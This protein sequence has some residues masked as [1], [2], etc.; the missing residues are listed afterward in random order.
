MIP[1]DDI[2]TAVVTG[3][4]AHLGIE[5]VRTNQNA[6]APAYPFG[7][8]TITTLAAANNGTWGKYADGKDR[9]QV[10]QIWSLS[11]QSDKSTEA[12]ILASKAH[13]WLDHAGHIYLKDMG[14]VVQSVGNI[15][16]RDN[17]L[18]ADYEYKY[19]FDVVFYIFDEVDNPDE[20]TGFIETADITRTN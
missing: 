17:I 12:A 3:L 2:R 15:T 20:G 19:G 4:K 8:Y 14:V 10:K 7:S 16:N 5:I 18:T 1:Y 13:A 6:P 9:K 11:F